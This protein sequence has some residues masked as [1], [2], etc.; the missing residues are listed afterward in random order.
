MGDE[1]GTWAYP[2]RQFRHETRVKQRA[3]RMEREL[4]RHR[5]ARP[6]FVAA[7]ASVLV[8][9]VNSQDSEERL[10]ALQA[11]AAAHPTLYKFYGSPQRARAR[12]DAIIAKRVVLVRLV[13]I[14]APTERHIVVIGDAQF[15]SNMRGSPPG[16]AGGLLRVIKEILPPERIFDIN[17]FRTSVLHNEAPHWCAPSPRRAA[18]ARRC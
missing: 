12:F 4:R 17:E 13:K 2:T 5:A 14:L 9:D 1:R 8:H 6:D 3:Q 16:A 10:R 11:R 15:G 18:R 7:E